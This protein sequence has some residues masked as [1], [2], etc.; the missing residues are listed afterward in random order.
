MSVQEH[1]KVSVFDTTLRDGEQ[2][3][4]NGIGPERKTELALQI[5]ALGVDLIE[6]GFPASSPS[7]RKATELISQHLKSARFVTFCRSNRADI[8]IAVE[9]GGTVNHQIQVMAT[10]SDMHLVHKRGI[11]RKE[12]VAEVIDAVTFARSLGMTDISVAIED[13]SR[14]EPE[15]LRAITE[16]AIEVGATTF[17]LADTSGCM[18]PAEYAKLV[19]TFR[20]WAPHPL[21]VSTHCHNDFGLST[22]NAIAGLEAG[23][24]EVQATVG[25][26]G[27]RA[28]NTPLEEVVA[29]LAYKKDLLGLWSSVSTERL[30]DVYGD[31][32][33]AIGL[34]GPRNKPIFG[35][36]A[37]ATAAGVHQ[38]GIFA[39]PAT[40]EYVEPM[41]FGRERKILVSRHSGRVVLRHILEELGIKADNNQLTSLYDLYIASRPDGDCEELSDLRERLAAELT[42]DESA[43]GAAAK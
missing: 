5:E 43:T 7:E 35:A 40:Y 9:A 27:E 12:A 13:A 30:C 2:A 23:A 1:R 38:Q 41:R 3:P 14:G 21:V 18:L 34:P 32:R 28:G 26:I 16:S 10:G 8:E 19:S 11:T 15:L 4:R 29:I 37:F 25:G 22:A 6:A 39:N 24:D 31:L 20:T 36:Y 17:V 42:H 33:D